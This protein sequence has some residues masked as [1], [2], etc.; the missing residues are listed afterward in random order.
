MAK[1]RLYQFP[2]SHYCE[3]SRWALDFKGVPFEIVNL[4]PG[5]HLLKTRR[6]APRTS[7]PILDYEGKILQ[8]STNI[9][10]FLET[11]YPSPPLF[12]DTAADRAEALE[13]EEYC[14]EEVGK[15]LRRFMY[16]HLLD[17]PKL[18]PRLLVEQSPWYE[19]YAFGLAY[20]GVKRLMRK[21]MRIYPPQV[22][23]SRVQLN[24]A[25][26][27]LDT[28]LKKRDFLVG[29][30]FSRADLSAASLLA[31]LFTPP[32]HEFPWPKNE[33]LP[34]PLQEF[35]ARWEDSHVEKWVRRLYRD[36]RKK[37]LNH[38]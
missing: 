36:Y 26:E 4:L 14:D 25:L 34:I 33:E 6:M 29:K 7:V 38:G 10:E 2:V 28:R 35:Q 9:L 22:E 17:E 16:H 1:I 23:K 11:T 18:M 37:G 13:W 32:E 30:H 20:P 8:D 24:A 21:A 5:F 15:H 3:K 12:P 31:P 27:K 19:R